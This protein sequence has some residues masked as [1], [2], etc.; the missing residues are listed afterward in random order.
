M[1]ISQIAASE[2]L[3]LVAPQRELE[4]SIQ[5]LKKPPAN[6]LSV[7]LKSST[8]TRFRFFFKSFTTISSLRN[9]LQNHRRLPECRNKEFGEG[10]GKD[11]QN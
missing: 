7:I 4:T 5:P 1:E 8:K 3:T 6:H 10:F 9:N 2:F 11:L